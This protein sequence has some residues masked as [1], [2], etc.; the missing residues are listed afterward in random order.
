MAPGMLLMATHH[1]QL[2]AMHNGSTSVISLTK[3][4]YQVQVSAAW[5]VCV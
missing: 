1:R 4:Q 5:C 3:G 2:Q